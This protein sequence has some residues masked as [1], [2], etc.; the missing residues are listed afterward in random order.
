MPKV[1]MLSRAAGPTFPGGTA[2]PGKV[3][4]LDDETAGR[5]IK[6]GYAELIE[7]PIA[8]AANSLQRKVKGRK[9]ETASKD[10]REE[11]RSS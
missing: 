8:R 2:E 3:V 4:N 7:G 6:G 9:R 5:L 11:T 10:P 1:R